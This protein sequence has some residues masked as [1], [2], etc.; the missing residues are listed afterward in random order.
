MGWIVLAIVVGGYFL[1]KILWSILKFKARAKTVEGCAFFINQ[2]L[3]QRAPEHK[4]E[5][6]DSVYRKT[7]HY[8]VN[9]NISSPSNMQS[10]RLCQY[11]VEIIEVE[12]I[13]RGIK[14]EED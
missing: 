14:L 7:V 5:L 13:L 1:F 11:I 4:H 6:Y 8:I 12:C 9:N 2:L 10:E 3:D